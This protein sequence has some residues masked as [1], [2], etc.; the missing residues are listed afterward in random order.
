LIHLLK[1]RLVE[2]FRHVRFTLGFDRPIT[3]LIWGT[4]KDVAATS[5]F[6]REDAAGIAGNGAGQ[7]ASALQAER[8]LETMQNLGARHVGGMGIDE[9]RICA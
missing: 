1:K 6:A 2:P 9:F 3:L 4:F 8:T 5:V 7:R